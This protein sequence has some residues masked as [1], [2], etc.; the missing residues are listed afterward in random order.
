MSKG[1]KQQF[2]QF[3]INSIQDACI[4]LGMLI[5]GVIVNLDKYK[6]YVS[7]VNILLENTDSEYV[8]AKEYYNVNDKLLFR[9]REILKLTADYQNGSFSYID[10]RKRLKNRGYLKSALPQDIDN[11]LS[12]LHDIR[13]WS[14]HNPQSMMVAAK[15]VAEKSIPKELKGY[16][17]ITH[18]LNPVIIQKFDKYELV[19]LASLSIYAD[20]KVEQFEKVLTQMKK[21]YQEL[22]DSIEDKSYNI[23]NKGIT[24]EVQYR[25]IHNIAKLIE[26]SKTAQIS[27]A[28][29]KSQYDGSE[30][31]YKNLILHPKVTSTQDFNSA[32]K[33]ID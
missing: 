4:V 7:E 13:N 15:E 33:T 30:E 9:Q 17:N 1:S 23:T 5:S 27:M 8:E 14:F 18:Q 2:K 12:E 19:L 29:Q 21:D 31:N 25:E 3:S 22:F 6:E 28:I 26:H 24:T 16:V 10:F 32:P 20:K 11:I